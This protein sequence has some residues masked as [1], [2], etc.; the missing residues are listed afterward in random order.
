[1]RCAVR[2]DEPGAIDS[3][4]DRQVLNRHVVHELVVAALQEGRIDRAEG[5]VAFRGQ[6]GGERHRMLL[7]D[8]DIEHPIGKD[9][10][11]SVEPSPVRH[12]RGNADDLRVATR[13]LDQ[14]VGEDTGVG[15]RVGL[16]LRL[17]ARD[18]VKRGNAVVLVIGR[19]GRRIALALLGHHVHEHRAVLH[20]AHILQ[21]RQKMVEIVAV[22][23][24]DVVEAELLEQGA[25][26][27]EIA[28]VFLG[29]PGLVVHELRQATRELLGGAA[30]RTIG[31]ARDEARE[32]GRH[33][34]GRRRDRH[35]VVVEDDNQP[36]AHGAGV[37]H[38]LVGHS[39]RHRAVAD[40]RDHMVVAVG[41]IARHR[42]AEAGR[43]RRR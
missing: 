38:R 8:A 34:A 6:A 13:L 30:Q 20:V 40:H 11:H 24:P 3:E 29:K 4:A 39:R 23:R 2:A 26:G 18:H 43:D 31:A 33:R 9:R 1:M 16:G 42:H 35:V 41:Q 19:F 12:G 28:A 21:D 27:P 32:I 14:R 15:G 10:F 5:L 25:A 7:G 17:R 37:V 22:D 36:R